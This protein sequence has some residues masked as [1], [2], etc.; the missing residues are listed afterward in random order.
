[1]R[2]ERKLRG[3][4]GSGQRHG[5]AAHTQA[6][7]KKGDMRSEG[8]G[9]ARSGGSHNG[10][11][12]MRRREERKE[13]RKKESAQSWEDAAC[14]SRKNEKEQ[15]TAR[16]NEGKNEKTEKSEKR[17]KRDKKNNEGIAP[18]PKGSTDAN[19]LGE[20]SS[21]EAYTSVC[22]GYALATFALFVLLLFT[23]YFVMVVRTLS[24]RCDSYRA[25]SPAC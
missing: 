14:F 9:N 3:E 21:D 11:R 10:D 1:M 19:D 20:S 15:R 13:G 8:A 6:K 2:G 16:S 12:R 7:A 25:S 17:E 22:V 5:A 4:S 24:H 18:A 23:A